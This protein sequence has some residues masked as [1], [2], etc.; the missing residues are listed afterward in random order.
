LIAGAIL[1]IQFAGTSTAS[2]GVGDKLRP[3]AADKN[4]LGAQ[5]AEGVRRQFTKVG[6]LPSFSLPSGPDNAVVYKSDCVT[7][8]SHFTAGDTV[9]VKDSNYQS[10]TRAIYWVNPDGAVVQTDPISSSAD[11][12]TRV[13]NQ[14]GTWKIYLV[15]FDQEA[16]DV[17]SFTVSDPARTTFDLWV[18]KNSSGDFS[19]NAVVT[20][21]VIA[22]NPGPDDATGVTLTEQT[23][24]DSSAVSFSQDSGPAFT[25][26]P[27][28]G[29]TV[30]TI[31]TL[32]AGSTATFSFFYQINAVSDG[33]VIGSS[34]TIED[35]T[36][37]SSSPSELHPED[38]VWT[39]SN[40]VQGAVSAG[41][42]SIGCP[43][44]V[45]K[46]A[47]T[48]QGSDSGAIVHFSTPSGNGECG[49]V[50][51]DHCN[52]CFF[53]VGTTTVTATSGDASCVF[54]VIVTPPAGNAAISCPGDHTANADNNCQAHIAIGTPTATGD[55]V[56]VSGVRSDGQPLY[57]CDC[58]PVNPSDPGVECEI[59]GAC[60]RRTD[61]PFS[62][63]VTTIL[64]TAYSHDVAGPYPDP[65]TE[66]AHRTG[67]AS[68]VQTFTVN[69]VTPP[70][71]T[72]SNTSASADANCQ[73]AIPDYS[74][75][76]T[77]TDNCACASS[78]TSQ[79][80]NTRTDITLVQSPLPGTLVGLG[81]HTITLSAN[82]GS[83]NNGGA[84][85][86][87]TVQVTFTVNDTTPPTFTFVPP[88]VS[89]TTGPG[90]TTCD[91]VISDATIGTAT[92]TD[93]CG[94]VTITRS[95]S[96]NTFP[97]GTTTITWT[98]TDGH[99]NS[100]TATQTITVVDNTPPVISCPSNV[101]A[102]L[103]LHTSA[104]SMAVNYP[105]ATATDNC[106][107][108]NIGYTAAPGSVF[109][110]GTTSV[111]AT[112]TDVNGNT[113]SCT[114][115]VTVL[116]DFTGFFPPVNNP[117][118]LNSVKAGSA[119]PVKFSL[120]GDKGLTIFLANSPQSGV[121][122]CDASAPVTDLVDTVT[123]GGS[124]LSYDA[125]SDQYVYTWKTDS[126]WA[127]SCRQLVVTLNDGSVHI[128]NFKFK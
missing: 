97:V 96:G 84:G 103:P 63:G 115:T 117:P 75:L 7:P 77:V 68:C 112:A 78:D 41:T 3:G 16:R 32:P 42:C 90:A 31:A 55:N 10:T 25:C 93:N 19:S 99:S 71:I 125:S 98:A 81:P 102:Y 65:Q 128:A 69:D 74:T 127:G 126:S 70:V 106:A 51:V 91:T 114:F 58:Y 108:A 22:Q 57:N 1:A 104:T 67:S 101:V 89:A 2:R 62:A 73:A 76:A 9:C 4:G 45:T 120:S 33:T 56:T 54:N 12:S 80:C 116:Y 30:C 28:P 113:A 88:A 124:S 72:A 29:N 39:T 107:V 123:A 43:E 27:G 6:L 64:W 11:S 18:F 82:D 34:V 83:S 60:S 85:N 38:N 86:T 36:T 14:P 37:G 48:T 20:Y 118:T 87:T 95:P 13:V 119:I 122:P 79:L 8:E 92:A 15:G 61:A 94:S 5:H 23:P 24:N 52:D 111:T 40:V 53:P 26:T 35:S 59:T 66:E 105:A 49:A 110:V 46:E 121:I 44:N 21:Q 47:D 17:A 50:T 109:P 100:S